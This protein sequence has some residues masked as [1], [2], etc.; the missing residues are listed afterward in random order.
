MRSGH[1]GTT[2]APVLCAGVGATWAGR[3]AIRLAS[4][5]VPALEFGRAALGIV[6]PHPAAAAVLAGLLSGRIPPAYGQ[7]AV[8]GYDLTRPAGRVAARP[9]IGVASRTTRT[10]PGTTIRRLVE[11]AAKRQGARRCDRSLLVAAIL[12][13]LRLTPWAD[14]QLMAAPSLVN[15][16]ARLAAACVHQPE[17][18]VI[19]GLFDHLQPADRVAL[20]RIVTELKRDTSIVVIGADADPM[21]LCCDQLVTEADGIV[22]GQRQVTPELPSSSVHDVSKF[23]PL[24]HAR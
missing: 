4:F 20:A 12:D 2:I 5:Q 18:L 13:R 24:D 22:L 23:P 21:L 11:H 19:E 8:L 1:A 6:T 10:W 7:L 9:G 17:L 14:V 16:R 15:R 3:Y